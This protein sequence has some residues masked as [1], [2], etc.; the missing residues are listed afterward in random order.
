MALSMGSAA[1]AQE[2]PSSAASEEIIVTGSRVVLNG[3]DSPTP[4]TVVSIEQMAEVRP[5]TVA[6]QLNELPQFANSQGQ[7]NAV[8][9]GSANAGNPNGQANVLNLRNF[10][11][12]RNLVLFDGHR[13]APNS[14]NGTV[15]IDMIPQL[16][17]KRVDIVTGGA[18][19]VYGSGAVTGVVNFITDT[20]FQ[21]V[22]LNGSYGISTKGDGRQVDAA[23]AWGAQLGDRAHVLF[24]YQFRDD[25]GIDK[26]SSRAW[27]AARYQIGAVNTVNGV[28]N[29]R[30]VTLA[31][32]PSASFGGTLANG[33][34]SSFT[35]PTA[36]QNTYF[37]SPNTLAPVTG[38]FVNSNVAG[39]SSASYF[40][41][42]L[43]GALRM[44]QVFARFDYD[45][46]DDIKLYARGAYTKNRNLAYAIAN[47]SYQASNGSNAH[48]VF[49][50]NPYLPTSIQNQM[51]AVSGVTTSSTFSINKAFGGDAM[52]QYRQLTESYGSN[53]SF[54]VGLNGDFGKNWKWELSFIHS[55]NKLRTIQNNAIN[56]RKLAASIDAV[57]DGGT[58]KCY[59]NTAA[60]QAALSAALK[61][62]YSG[63]V[64]F[65]SL[66]GPSITPEEA[67]WI[68]DPLEVTTNTRMDDVEG[69]ISGS[70]FDTWAGPVS[71]ALSGQARK[72]S[73]EVVSGSTPATLTNPLDCS[74]LR[75][76]ACTGTS[77]EYFQAESL[78]RPKTSVTVKEA[79]FEANVPLLADMALAKSLAVSGAFRASDYSTSG[80]IT[81]WK[82]GLDWDV[83]DELSLRLT[84][85]RDIRAPTMHELFAP[86]T[87]GNFNGRDELLGVSLDGAS[88]RPS[89]AGAVNSGN[90]RLRPEIANTLTVGAVYRPS[91]ASGLSIAV[92]YYDIKVRDA[93]VTLNGQDSSTQTDCIRSGGASATCALIVRTIDCCT[94][95]TAGNAITRVFSSPINI[96]RHYTRGVDMEFNYVTRMMDRPLNLRALVS[97]QP[98]N[99]LVDGISGQQTNIAGTGAGVGAFT[100]APKWRATLLA[101]MEV[102]DKLRIAIQERYRGAMGFY[103]TYAGPAGLTLPSFSLTG[104]P[105]NIAARFYT[106]LNVTYKVGP[107]DVYLN[108]QNLFN[109][110]PAPYANPNAPFPG[111]NGVAP[112]DDPIGRYFTLGFRARF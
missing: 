90:S 50:G 103:P 93:I 19:A 30:F 20:K 45:L 73:Y 26:R 4:V 77:L 12:T 60:G 81:S 63:C 10:G 86:Q 112:G 67:N 94:T 34:L 18:S 31:G 109:A 102:T 100:G 32:R 14:P 97:Y 106:N 47:P 7:G 53:Y 72:Q 48:A 98:K 44:H 8:G 22:K 59:V 92:D 23:F 3:N 17:L 82:A 95:T 110:G 52:N 62:F 21:G 89:P 27:G 15:D 83:T 39:N 46:T 24:S 84:R 71:V 101:N 43:R 64:P 111:L 40:D 41:Q 25:E 55:M 69:F 35:L 38:D 70:P 37:V 57:N 107:A 78:S 96:G 36:L 61:N 9:G 28:Q 11:L 16:L 29:Q 33:G 108:V 75:L 49:V 74:G 99:V 68:F 13:V 80:T 56:G 5:G 54:D 58:V 2:T 1:F 6:E 42:S 87:V 88:G 104:A 105:E 51:L 66:F 76:I 91:W 85:S 65:K 79:A